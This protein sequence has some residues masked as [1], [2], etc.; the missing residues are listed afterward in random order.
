MIE[1]TETPIDHVAAVE[2]V[3]SNRAGAVC[4]FLGTVRELT[5]ERETARLEYEAYGEMAR[6]SLAG[7]EAEARRRWPVVEL[8]IVHRVGVLGPGDV[9][10]VIAVSCPHRDEAFEACRWLIDALKGETPIWKKEVAPDGS[11]EWVHHA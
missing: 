5:G 4:S 7:L 11:G 6:K 8:A 2:S 9:A 3:R 1:I 10:V